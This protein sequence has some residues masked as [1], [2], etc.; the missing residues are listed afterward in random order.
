MRDAF[1]GGFLLN[2]GLE[3]EFVDPAAPEGLREIVKRT[4]FVPAVAATARFFSAD[5]KTLD[6][7]S[8]QQIRMDP[9]LGQYPRL[10]L[11]QR[12]RR[13]ALGMIN[14]SHL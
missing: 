10:A 11:P 1:L 14:P 7:G 3:Q 8:A 13:L 4:V 2:F 9:E 6:V 12:E 5:R